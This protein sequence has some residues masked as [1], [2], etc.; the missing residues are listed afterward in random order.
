MVRKYCGTINSCELSYHIK[1][2]SG[3][4][5]QDIDIDDTGEEEEGDDDDMVVEIIITFLDMVVVYLAPAF[6]QIRSEI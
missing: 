2:D 6:M 5:W 3:K 1:G 4:V